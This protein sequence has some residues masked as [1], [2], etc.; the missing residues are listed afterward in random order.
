MQQESDDVAALD[1]YK[2]DIIH[3]GY[4]LY[5]IGT[6]KNIKESTNVRAKLPGG[7]G[8]INLKAIALTFPMNACDVYVSMK[9][10][11]E[12]YGGS[13]SE[14]NAIYFEKM[15]IVRK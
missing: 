2:D 4:H 7:A 12:V 10:T 15:I 1:V 6:V 14:E 13:P 9:C 3:G 5:K 8:S 11:G